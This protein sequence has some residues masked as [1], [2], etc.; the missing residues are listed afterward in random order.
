VEGRRDTKQAEKDYLRRAA[1][2]EWEKFKPFSPPGTNTLADSIPLMQDF[3]GALAILQ[4]TPTDLILDLGAGACWCTDWLARLNLRTISVDIAH[5]MLRVGQSR[6]PP[7]ARTRLAAGDMEQLPFA[8]GVFDKAICL[9]AL[10]HVPSIEKALGEIARV[11]TPGGS[12]LFSEPGAGHSERPGSV[13]ATRDFGVLEQDILVDDFMAACQ[14]AGFADVRLKPMSYVI[15]GFDL[16]HEQWEAWTRLA[17]QRRPFR[18]WEKL[19]RAVLELVGAGKRD[20]LFEEAFAMNLVRLLRGAMEDHPVVVASKKAPGVAAGDALSAGIRLVDAP[21]RLSVRAGER[22]ELTALIS[23]RG[24]TPWPSGSA[25]S[26]PGRVQLGI[27]LLDEQL[28]LADRDYQRVPLAGDVAP[29]ASA[30]L[31]CVCHAP[32]SAGR[33]ALKLDL[34]MEGVTWF[35]PRGST[36]LTLPLQVDPA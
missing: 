31:K 17:R 8:S 33:Y 16:T 7:A 25:S 26:T 27:Q 13:A 6:V 9:S 23:N 2:G 19:W 15:A 21:Q 32:G 12:V 20:V 4:P 30:R 34:V 11:L 24:Q 14:R 1:A 28:R 22:F 10:H 29:G 36:A 5:D 3:A 35:E 18:A